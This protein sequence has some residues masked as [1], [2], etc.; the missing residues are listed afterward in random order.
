[1]GEAVTRRK[2]K[3]KLL[4]VDEAGGCCA[5][6]GYDPCILNLHFHHVD[7]AEK[8]FVLSSSTTMSLAAYREELQ[9]CVLVCANCHGEI[10]AGLLVSPPAGATFEDVSY[11]YASPHQVEG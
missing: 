4:L 10:E 8:S 11:R 2:Q 7:P 3:V 5:I 9:K 1:M 6:C